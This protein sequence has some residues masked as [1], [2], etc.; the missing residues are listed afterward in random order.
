MDKQK[1]YDRTR[2]FF[3]RP[4]AQLSA[5]FHE[6]SLGVEQCFYR[7]DPNVVLPENAAGFGHPYPPEKHYPEAPLACGIGCHI[8]NDMYTHQME[9]RSV[10]ILLQQY[11]AVQTLLGVKDD[12]DI[13]W[14]GQLQDAHDRATGAADCVARLD[15]LAAESG[16]RVGPTLTQRLRGWLSGIPDRYRQR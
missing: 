1:I 15:D 16:L 11:P 8:P 10:R 4:G 9:G 7:F 13:Q 2:A 5:K 6:G 14:L 3:A 12:D